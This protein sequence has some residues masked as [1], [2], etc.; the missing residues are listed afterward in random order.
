MSAR[1]TIAV[2]VGGT[3]TDAALVTVEGRLHVAKVRST[4]HD[5]GIALIA[6]VERLLADA[7]LRIDEIDA[8]VHGTT[9]ATNAVIAGDFARVGL[10]TTA[11]FEDVLQIATQQRADLY[12]PWLPRPAPLVP[13]DRVHGVRERTGADGAVIDPLVEA[14]VRA[15]ARAWRGHVDAVAVSF[16]FSFAG[17]GHERQAG[18]ILADDLP[19]VPVTLSCEV[20]PEFREY[21]RTATTV[22]NAALLPG[23]GGYLERLERRLRDR[24]FGGAFQLMGSA[25][26]IVPAAL[27]ARLPVSLLVSGP[28]AGAVAA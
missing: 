23:T 7:G 21:P 6:A 2:D 11:G 26:G 22:L 5:P 17:T 18:R 14:D 12:D 28:A 8:L 25:G 27:A 19:G 4:P 1:A 15:A 20:A 3:H 10:L 24:G 9:V 16:L 13:R